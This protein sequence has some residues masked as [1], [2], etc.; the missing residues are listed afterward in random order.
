MK[1]YYV[2][3]KGDKEWDEIEADDPEHAVYSFCVDYYHTP[4]WD[5]VEKIV[6]VKR[7]GK[8]TVYIEFEPEYYIGEI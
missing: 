7:N 1:K 8:F 5:G 6:E 4:D 2:R 3:E